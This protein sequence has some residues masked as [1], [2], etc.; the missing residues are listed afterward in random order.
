[1]PYNDPHAAPRAEGPTRHDEARPAPTGRRRSSGKPAFRTPILRAGLAGIAALLTLTVTASWT[2]A[3]AS[4]ADASTGSSVTT[5]ST[6]YLPEPTGPHPVGTTSLRLEDTSR[7]DPWVPEAESRELMVSLWYPA[8]SRNGRRA[9]YMTPKES[10]LILK[11]KGVTG[12]PSDVLS[13]TRTNAFSGAEP[14]GRGHTLPLVVLSPG[15]TD[16]RSSLTALAEELAS[17]GYVVAAIDHTYETFATTFPGGR[18]T[19]CAACELEGVDDFGEKAVKNRAVDVSFVIDQLTGPHATWTGASLIDA[20]RIA[21]AGTSLGGAS[22]AETMLKDSRVRAGINMDGL[23]FAPIPARGLARPFLFLGQPLHSPGGMDATWDRDW[24]HL[25]GWRRWLVVAGAVHPSF[26][27]YDLL[28]QQ[29]GVDLGS[30]LPG[31]RSVDITRRYVR[32]FFD[33]HLRG[34]PQPLLHRPS[35]R[36]P[37][38]EFCSP[39]TKTCG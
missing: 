12:V 16:P 20:S 36:Y 2:P 13:R 8:R 21:M 4:S 9:P 17:R 33:L 28:A 27:D 35:V 18:V 31:R 3:S 15:F 14:A 25:T 1:M 10:E 23:M 34:K 39:E 19:T 38:V 11:G 5:S 24:E 30:E 37:E 32:A 6:P 22:V 7:P 26:S 29:I